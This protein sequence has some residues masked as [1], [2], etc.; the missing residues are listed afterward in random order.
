M[1]TLLLHL[2]YVYKLEGRDFVTASPLAQNELRIHVSKTMNES[3]IFE[4]EGTRKRNLPKIHCEHVA[5]MA[6]PKRH[7]RQTTRIVD[8]TQ[9]CKI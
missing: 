9:R 5:F 3:T 8:A 7:V 1:K 4:N 6:T 2:E